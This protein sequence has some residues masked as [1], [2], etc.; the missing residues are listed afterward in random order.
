MD[1]K[2]KPS[3]VYIVANMNY[4]KIGMKKIYTTKEEVA[5]NY[6]WGEE[7]TITKVFH[8]AKTY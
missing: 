4:Y 8:I 2:T 6:Q 7:S 1:N 5:N 3:K